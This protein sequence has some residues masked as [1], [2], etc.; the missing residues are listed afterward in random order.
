MFF[1]PCLKHLFKTMPTLC[2]RPLKALSGDL[3]FRLFEKNEHLELSFL[4]H[5]Y[6]SIQETTCYKTGESGS[7]PFMN[8]KV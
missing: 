6:K 3:V 5:L 8:I 4:A 1:I 2:S 7:L